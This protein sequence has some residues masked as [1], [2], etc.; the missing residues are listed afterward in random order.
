MLRT[1]IID[2]SPR[3]RSTLRRLLAAHANITVV[4]EAG[5][6]AD[7][8]DRLLAQTDYD[9]VLLDIQLIGGSGF[10][11]VPHIAD[12]ARIIFAT[13]FEEHAV[14]AFEVNALDY[15][16]KPITAERLAAALQRIEARPAASIDRPPP[17]ATD[18]L[19]VPTTNGSRF[20]SLADL[21][22]I[23]AEQNYTRLDL[24]DGSRHLAQRTM[25]EW[26][27]LLPPDTFARIHRQFIINLRR[28]TG[29][30]HDLIGRP[31]VYLSGY[32]TPLR[33]SRRQWSEVR[34]LIPHV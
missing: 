9:L 6:V 29:I 16:L 25:K 13:A 19:F 32:P 20:I 27:E 7:A 23:T 4:G 2:D 8:R 31:Q 28:I 24:A 30:T 12:T 22:V 33:P 26:E 3:S 14:R 11:L 10:D 17:V 34:D 18:A 21:T 1:L 5:N 15:I